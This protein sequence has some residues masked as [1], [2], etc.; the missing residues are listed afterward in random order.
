VT[1][2]A[3]TTGAPLDDGW[4]RIFTVEGQPVALE[5]MTFI[6]HIVVTPGYFRTLDIP[7][8]QG[9]DFDESDF[10]T[11]NLIVSRGFASRHFGAGPA[12]GKRIRFGPPKNNE[13]WCTIVGVVA[14]S[15]HD[16]LKGIERDSVYLPYSDDLIPQTLLVRTSTATAGLAGTIE[17]RIH[18][19]DPDVAV[20]ASATLDELVDRRAW[21]DRFLAVLFGVFAL[22]AL[23]LAASGFYAVLAYTVSLQTHEIGVRMAL[24]A[25]ASSVRGMILQQAM[26]LAGAGL[27]IGLVSAA[28]LAYLLRTQLYN[29][30]P[31]DPVSY[32]VAPAVFVLSGWLAAAI[33]S[34][35]ATR[36]DPLVALRHE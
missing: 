12:L 20:T 17:S 3:F 8:Q 11:K 22:L 23:G 13:P 10:G 29:V 21:Q 14:D 36:V 2:A 35:R 31:L 1:H 15:R 5:A 28:A 7:L 6:N 9:R 25:T 24:G 18:A 27:A 32:I 33:P 30:S 4:G 26:T 16:V 19:I 34:R